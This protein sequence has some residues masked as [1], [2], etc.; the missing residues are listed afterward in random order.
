MIRAAV[1][2]LIL[3]L[4]QFAPA[5]DL[6]L[7]LIKLI[8]NGSGRT[9][10]VSTSL[11]RFVKTAGLGDHPSGP[12]LDIAIRERLNIGPN[13]AAEMRVDSPSD[14]LT[15]TVKLH[16]ET[17]IAG[18]RFDKSTPSA[19]TIISTYDGN[20]ITSEEV[21]DHDKP[22]P[23][24]LGMLGAGI[25]HIVSGLDHILFVV[26]LA[27]L[28]GGWKTLLKVLTAFTVAHTLTLVIASLGWIHGNPR[29]IEPLIALSIVALAVEGLCRK[30]RSANESVVLRVVIAFGFGLV[31]GF[32]FAGGLIELGLQGNLLAYNLL[33][34]SIG[35]ELGQLLILAPTVLLIRAVTRVSQEEGQRFVMAA[36]ICLGMIGCF[37]LFE[38]LF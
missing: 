7:T 23:I 5:H 38:R 1:T 10:E 25:Q 9:I 22:K 27:L 29:V 6:D 36:S 11:S 30:N 19:R 18:G 20:Q 17:D 3:L 8:R 34:F 35:I 14:L 26:G 24:F 13:V 4:V 32:G 2:G 15:W 33:P 12:S 16:G 28:G 21:F 37:W 31:H